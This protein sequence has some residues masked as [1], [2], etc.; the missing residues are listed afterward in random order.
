MRGS[1]GVVALAAALV[2]AV[3]AGADLR[4]VRR[5]FGELSIPRVRA[6]EI[7][8]PAER[9]RGRVRTI[10]RLAEPPLAQYSRGLQA[11]S[12]RRKLNVRSASSRAYLSRLAASQ[13][14]AEAQLRRAIPEATVSRRFRVILNGL[15]VEL[16]ASRLPTLVRQPF[17]TRVYPSL[18]YTL[19]LN[20][21]PSI[22][23]ADTIAQLTGARGEG[24]KIA[25]VDDGVDTTNPFFDPTGFSYPAG[26][27]KGATRWTSPK[28]IVARAF[29]GP[30]SGR[31]GRL[32]VDPRA[33]FHGTHV[34]GIAAGDAGTDAPSGQ[35]HPATP[36]LS[37]VAP[38]AWIGNYRVFNVPSPI[39]HIANTPEIVAA[40]EAAVSDGMDVIN[41]SGGGAQSEPATDAFT[42]SV[43]N[44]VA[45]GVVM[46]ASAGNDRDDFGW[47]T[48]GSPATTPDA[49]SVAATS[50]SQVFAPALSIVAPGVPGNLAAIPFVPARGTNIPGAWGVGERPLVDVGTIVGT[51]GAPVDPLLCGPPENPNA[52]GSTLPANSLS[53]ALALVS[54]GRCTFV[55]KAAR[56]RA[57]GA[58]GIVIV[59]N[60]PGEANPIPI[61]LAIP[62]GMISDLDGTRLRIFMAATGG[63]TLARLNSAP[64]RIETGRSGIVT[65]F[66]SAG[67]TAFGHLLKPDVAAPGGQ[68][69]SATLRNAGGPFA[70]FDGTSMSSP[71]VAG[72]AALL[73]QLHRG[74]TPRQVKSALVSTAGPAWA[75]TAR[76]V[77]APVVL[78]GGGLVNLPRANDPKLFTDPVSLSFGDL[79]VN[80]GARSEALLVRLGDAGDGAG[81]WQVELRPQLTSAGASIGLP[82]AVTL[83]P[84]GETEI[85]VVVR[86]AGDAAAGDNFGFIVLRRGDV[87]RRIPYLFAVTRPAL[88]SVRATPLRRVQVG[89][90]LTGPSRVSQYRW[91][92]SAFG[93]PPTYLAEPPM[94]QDGAERLYVTRLNDPAVNIGAAVVVSSGTSQPDP[95]FLG[96]PD[97]N[98]VQGYTGTPVNV[99]ALTF[100]YRADLGV[101]GAFFPRPKA[102][103]V[104]V[105]AGRDPFTGRLLS[106]RYV[107]RSWV[108]DVF[109]PLIVPL[110]TRVSAGRPT[111]IARVVDGAFGEPASGVDPLSLVIGYRRVLVGAAVYDPLSGIA[112]FPLPREAPVLRSGRTRAVIAASD[113]Q[114]AKNVNTSGPDPLPN[115]N[116][117]PATLTVVSGPTVTWVA[118][119][120]NECA[121]QR[122]RLVVVAGS[123]TRVRSVRFL[124]GSQR[125]GTDARGAAGLFAVTWRTRGESR[126]RH[127]LRAIVVDSQGREAEATRLVRICRRR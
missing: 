45:A 51:N 96:S 98:D 18:R 24:I 105:D 39:G 50:N 127:A 63:R 116:A 49:I 60:R 84:G 55:S 28:V 20:D 70:V 119:E 9:A 4:P 48:A 2:L 57:A 91:P 117:R 99:N 111:L 93:H 66:S 104:A 103:Y 92:S 86:A 109:P 30:N 74:W 126:G 115:T 95:W 31:G 71:H 6:G 80:R 118:P 97:E 15:A 32:A 36:G 113:L 89:D 114:E 87:T 35:D 110:T 22:I 76:T 62:G 79:N 77:E 1:L 23:G 42:E 7:H 37:G 90:T 65:S 124:D 27:P 52:Q 14:R 56:A 43:R 81:T 13:R 83:A 75:D 26:F 59:D 69:L 5:D 41:F 10:V 85:A 54:R 108:N 40:F 12:G 101:A 125:I 17:V 122:T 67:P 82:P 106:G 112:V 123:S 53:G 121:A 21:S 38:R 3:P 44:V 68:I 88:E 61:T 8:I 25:V 19:S 100:S 33:S 64:E 73:L 11:A 47:G 78:Q 94:R 29:P 46:V 120:R 58:R 107:L 72:S 16:P 102:Y 34:A